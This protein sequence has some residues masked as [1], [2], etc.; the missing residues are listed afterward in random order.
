MGSP[1]EVDIW[2]ADVP[3]SLASE[4]TD[5]LDSFNVVYSRFRDDSLIAQ[6][7]TESGRVTVPADF[8]Q[9][10]RMFFKLYEVTGG[11]MNP[12]I[13]QSLSDA[14]YDKAYSLNPK[15]DIAETPA[16]PEVLHI[17]DDQTIELSRPV[18]IDLGAIGKGYA[19]DKLVALLQQRG[20]QSFVVNGSG[21]MRH[22]GDHVLTVGLEH[23][24][25]S[26]KVIGTIELQNGSLASSGS[27][28]R[29]WENYHHILDPETNSSP[30]YIRAS[31]VR[32]Q[33]A[34]EADLIATA[35]FLVAP[36]VL[37]DSYDFEYVLINQELRIKKSDGWGGLLFS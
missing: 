6:L 37:Q 3:D 17:I 11:K 10:M 35:L 18:L 20:L 19:V 27:N 25:D 21:D 8:T 4:V 7:A 33:T 24:D 1:W 29:A 31:W 14:G 36:E 22:I 26:T 30:D 23:P 12:L 15:D 13:G 5:F 2:D 16:L 28:R 32:A 34:T 9:M